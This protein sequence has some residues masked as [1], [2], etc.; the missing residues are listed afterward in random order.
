MHTYTERKSI[1]Q[2][3]RQT[4][5]KSFCCDGALRKQEGELRR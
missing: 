4:W 5:R 3:H 1:L 2:P